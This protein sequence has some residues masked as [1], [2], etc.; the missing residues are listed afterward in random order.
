MNTEAW[1]GGY[2]VDF[3]NLQKNYPST[4]PKDLASLGYEGLTSMYFSSD[5]PLA[6]VF[7]LPAKRCLAIAFDAGESFRSACCRDGILTTS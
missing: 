1:V 6:F 7:C 4:A 2:P 5:Q 3:A